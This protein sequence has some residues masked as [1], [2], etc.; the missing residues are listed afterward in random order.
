[1]DKFRRFKKRTHNQQ[2]LAPDSGIK[3]ASI[4]EI[5]EPIFERKH[6]ES[7]YIISTVSIENLTSTVERAKS[8]YPSRPLCLVSRWCIW[9]LVDRSYPD[10]KVMSHFVTSNFVIKDELEEVQFGDSIMSDEIVSIEND[11][12]AHTSRRLFILVG[13]GYQKKGLF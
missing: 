4:H 9:E 11:Y 1:M 3:I 7:K 2:N 5:L 8:L 13:Q 12:I 10:R 6:L